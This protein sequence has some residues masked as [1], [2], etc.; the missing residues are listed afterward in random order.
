[1]RASGSLLCQLGTSTGTPI[2]SATDWM[3]VGAVD[4]LVC[5][6]KRN[7]TLWCGGTGQGGELG[8]GDAWRTSPVRVLTTP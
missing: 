1:M 8:H 7:G 4:P 2:D 3:S 6:V 5:G